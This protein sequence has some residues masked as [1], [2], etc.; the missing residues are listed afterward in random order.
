MS[1]VTPGT[2]VGAE[3]LWTDV[4]NS[5]RQGAVAQ[6]L[7]PDDPDTPRPARPEVSKERADDDVPIRVR[8]GW[9]AG[10]PIEEEGDLF[11]STV[12]LAARIASEGKGGEILVSDVIRQLV[13][14]K[15]FLFND[16]GEHALRGSRTPCV[17][18]K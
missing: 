7:R 10:E 16:R 5:N 4:P 3:Q 13:T 15:G 8:I 6:P 18:S 14:G 9:N 1:V 17:S 11:G 2:T 12:I